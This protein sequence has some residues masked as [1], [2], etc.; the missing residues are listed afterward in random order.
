MNTQ[1][2][3]QNNLLFK[4]TLSAIFIALGTVLSLVKLFQMPLGGSV[5]LVSTLPLLLLAYMFGV[6][7]GLLCGFVYSLIQMF[8]SLG[9]A[10]GWGMTPFNLVGMLLFDYIIAY[11]VLGFAGVPKAIMGAKD[12]KL[13]TTNKAVTYFGGFMLA[14]LLR[15][16]SHIISGMIFCA[17]W[18]PEEWDNLFLY[19]LAYNGGF[20][21]PDFAITLVAAAAVFVPISKLQE[22]YL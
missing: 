12:R 4:L 5:T 16:C 19:S 8:M 22:R 15:L 9:A 2:K 20:L 3:K 14:T 17:A 7:W 18:M 13:S 10:M 11:T 1:T 6:R 21:A